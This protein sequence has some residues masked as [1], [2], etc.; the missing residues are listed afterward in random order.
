MATAVFT[1]CPPFWPPSWIFQKFYFSQ[2]C[3]KFTG[4]RRKH[5]FLASNTKI[6]ENRV[7]RKNFQ[8]IFPKSYN[9]LF[10]TVICIINCALN[11]KWWRHSN[12]AKRCAHY[13][14]TGT[15]SFI[16]VAWK[17]PILGPKNLWGVHL[18]PPPPALDVRGLNHPVR[19]VR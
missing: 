16:L 13:Q 1:T 18:I 3:N 4:I 15:E 2:N 11:Y 8:Q 9:F 19:Q 5:V 7:K 17:L 10:W 14:T 12:N 6:I